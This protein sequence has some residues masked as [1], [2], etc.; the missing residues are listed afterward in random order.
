MDGQ[1]RSK[2][3]KRKW[4]DK[5]YRQNMIE[6]HVGYIMPKDQKE[7]IRKATEGR[8]ISSRTKKK[9][10][11]AQ[12]GK[13]HTLETRKK[14]SEISSR[15]I[16]KK[17]HN[18]KGGKS[19]KKGYH[20]IYMKRYRARKYNAIGSHTREEWEYL[21]KKYNYM[22]LC[23]KEFEPEIK[24][25]E[26]HIIPLSLEGSDNIENIQPLCQSCNS[27]KYN[28][29]INFIPLNFIREKELTNL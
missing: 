21:K 12:Q 19:K 9:M 26:D 6:A 23:C 8:I 7:K 5:K 1:A 18:W 28:K 15:R 13:H 4:E 22:C 16:N 14:L 20:D 25:T 11:L 27:R 10:S 17:S 29:I 24:L 3:M 2:M